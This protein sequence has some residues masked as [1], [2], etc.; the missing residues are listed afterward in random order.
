VTG[1]N[2]MTAADLNGMNTRLLTQAADVS[3][4]MLEA[5]LRGDSIAGANGKQV[6]LAS[7]LGTG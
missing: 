5:L 4:K 3:L 2:E 1:G 7:M 6:T